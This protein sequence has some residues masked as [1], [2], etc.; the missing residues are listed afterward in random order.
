MNYAQGMGELHR[1][2][3]RIWVSSTFV[4]VTEVGK[5]NVI[6]IGPMIEILQMPNY[7][8]PIDRAVCGIFLVILYSSRD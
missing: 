2:F 8:P 7:I 4:I 5:D 6:E 3:D 1:V